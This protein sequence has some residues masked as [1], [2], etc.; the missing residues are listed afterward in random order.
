VKRMRPENEALGEIIDLG[1]RVLGQ[2]RGVVHFTVG[3]RR[4]IEIGG[5]KEPLYVIR[6]EP[7]RARIVVGPRRALAVEAMRV[8]DWNWLGE[9]QREVSV[10]VRSLAPAVPA[11]RDGERV[12]F[13]EA[14][15]GVAPGQASVLYDGTRLLGGGWIAETEASAESIVNAAAA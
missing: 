6:I 13:R 5:Q 7:E 14:E 10:K 3:Q 11:V 15:Y 2:H 12:R 9:D 8:A 1:G 4:G